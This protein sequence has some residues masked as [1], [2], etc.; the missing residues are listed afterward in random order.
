MMKSL[1]LP[2]VLGLWGPLSL[3]SLATK[4]QKL[5]KKS[6]S[7][8][9]AASGDG[10]QVPRETVTEAHQAQLATPL[11]AQPAGGSAYGGSAQAPPGAPYVPS[12]GGSAAVPASS[13]GG[14]AAAPMGGTAGSSTDRGLVLPPTPGKGPRKGNIAY[15]SAEDGAAA[16]IAAGTLVTGETPRSKTI[17]EDSDA[18]ME[19]YMRHYH[20][21]LN[22]KAG[23]EPAAGSSGA[24]HAVVTTYAAGD[25]SPRS[26]T[27]ALTDP[28]ANV[29]RRSQDL[30]MSIDRFVLEQ[31]TRDQYDAVSTKER[32]RRFASFLRNDVLN[33]KIIATLSTLAL[34]SIMAHILEPEVTDKPITG[35]L[36]QLGFSIPFY[37]VLALGDYW[38]TKADP[39]LQI[40]RKK[41][42]ELEGKVQDLK[43]VRNNL[44]RWRNDV[45]W[46]AR[47]EKLGL[48][49]DGSNELSVVNLNS[50]RDSL[51]NLNIIQPA[52]RALSNIVA[53][54]G[55]K[56]E[57]QPHPTSFPSSM[58]A[59]PME[60]LSSAVHPGPATGALDPVRKYWFTHMTEDKKNEWRIKLQGYA[61]RVNNA[62]AFENRITQEI[63]EEF[64]LQLALIDEMRARAVG[65]YL[66]RCE[67]EQEQD[68]DSDS[69][70]EA[71]DAESQQAREV[72]EKL[73]PA[74]EDELSDL[75]AG[76]S[77]KTKLNCLRRN[78]RKFWA[79]GT[80]PAKAA[81][82]EHTF[83]TLQ[84]DLYPITDEFHDAVAD[85]TVTGRVGYKTDNGQRLLWAG[86]KSALT[87]LSKVR[88]KET[89]ANIQLILDAMDH[90]A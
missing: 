52:K 44:R 72:I 32:A 22:M 29:R 51:P 45:E 24:A 7:F 36:V 20:N 77:A 74:Q 64:Y 83:Q 50:S 38:N 55:I 58:G 9:P 63:E 76:C 87:M 15:V 28:A 61:K 27:A 48:F 60:Q 34:G 16:Q 23:R 8:V 79:C 37:S 71:E 1:V 40:V 66:A 67:E 2:V 80:A 12:V 19:E 73:T 39:K 68:S 21:H 42:A 26:E 14:S 59:H 49:D 78:W 89:I 70:V 3:G 46:I 88:A 84:Q 47:G 69:E 13:V 62:L 54:K 75:I 57:I 5:L 6:S 10:E 65:E 11:L 85:A 90:T 35:P 30:S 25:E 81:D 53:G 17:E 43:V 56:G 82:G 41:Y 18:E 86:K 4:L 33:G 31:N